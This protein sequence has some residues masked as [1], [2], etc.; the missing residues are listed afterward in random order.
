MMHICTCTL[1]PLLLAGTTRS[2]GLSV[3]HVQY[4]VPVVHS[5]LTKVLQECHGP[6][7]S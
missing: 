3:Y 5:M 2:V 6:G 7:T 4:V 1:L